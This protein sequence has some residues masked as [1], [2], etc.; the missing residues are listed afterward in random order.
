VV[1]EN[2][3]NAVVPAATPRLETWDGPASS[4]PAR[5]DRRGV[6][7]VAFESGL[8]GLSS[9][10]AGGITN[11]YRLAHPRRGSFPYAGR[12]RSD[13]VTQAGVRDLQ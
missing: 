8:L 11:A 1:V 7:D 6:L 3:D 10:T 5:W 9:G 13:C 2:I 4:D 12:T